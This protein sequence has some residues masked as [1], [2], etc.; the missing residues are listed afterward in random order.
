MS[1]GQLLF[2]PIL[3]LLNLFT[4]KLNA[5]VVA[6]FSAN[7]TSG[8]GSLQ[9]SFTD[10]STSSAGTISSWSW[11]L[12]GVASSSQNP[13]RIFG[14][15]GFYT[16]CLTATDNLGNSATECKQEYIQ[17]YQLPEPDFSVASQQGCV[18]F[19]VEFTDLTTLG[20]AAINQWIWGLGGSA[21][22]VV[23]DGSLNEIKT[24]YSAPDEY[25][26]SLTVI[27]DNNCSN[28][29]T[30]TDYISVTSPP[31]VDVS[32]NQ[33]FNCTPPFIVSFSN[34]GN[35]ANMDFNWDFGNGASF[36]GATPNPVV[37]NDPGY[38]TVTVIGTDQISG[39]S[40]T[41]VLLDYIQVGYPVEFSYDPLFTCANGSINFTDD[42]SN[43]ADSVL[44]D[45]G[46]GITSTAP[47]P[48]YTYP[49]QGCF[50]VSLTRYIGGCATTEVAQNCIIVHPNPT[51]SYSNNNSIGCD[52]PHQVDFS[53][54]SDIATQWFWDFGDGTTSTVQNPTHTYTQYGVFPV[55]LTVTDRNG[56]TNVINT[57][58]VEL[59]ALD[60]QLV[61]TRFFDCTPLSVT[62]EDQS[63]SIVPITTWEWHVINNASSPP[64]QVTSF[65]TVP[66]LTLIDTGRYD[67]ILIVTN[68]LGC[69]DTSL[70]QNMIGVG[71]PPTVDFSANPRVSCVS[72]SITFTDN[73]SSFSDEW[74]WDFG[75]G[76]LSAEQNP[77]YLYVDTG[78]FDVTLTAIH[79][80]CPNRLEID[81]FIHVTPPKARFSTDMNCDDPFTVSM[82]DN[83]I[84]ADTIFWDFGVPG[85]NADT[86]RERSPVFTY[87]ST[88]FY[89]VTQVVENFSTG[90]TDT[91]SFGFTIADP[92]ANFA[93][94]DVTGCVPVTVSLT[95]QSQDA[96]TYQWS[97]PGGTFSD[98]TT[99]SPRLTFD[100]P[101]AYS[102]IQL[103]ITDVNMC[104]DTM[105]F[106]DTIYANGVNLNFAIQPTT[107][108]QPLRV[109][110][111]ES[112]SSTF[113]TVIEWNWDFGDGQT[114]TIQ[115]PQHTFGTAGTYSPSLIVRDDWGCQASLQKTDSIDV[116]FPIA[117]FE[118]D[119]FGCTQYII[120]FI[121]QSQGKSLNYFWD[122]GDGRTS[123][124]N[125]PTHNYVNEG[126]YTVCLTVTDLY[127]CDST[128][129]RTDYIEIA[130]PVADFIADTIAASCPPLLVNFENRSQNANTYEWNF[131]DNSGSSNLEHPPHVYT[132]PGS[133]GVMLIATATE[134]CKD[135]LFL[136][137]L[138]QI[139][140]PLGDFS[141]DTDSA[142]IPSEVTFMGSSDGDYMYIWDY[143]NGVLDTSAIAA[144]TD[145]LGYT[146]TEIG[147]FIP[148]LI[149]VNQIGCARAIES[150]D[151][152]HMGNL[153]IDFLAQ[154]TVLCDQS[155]TSFF[156]TSNS[157]AP[158]NYQ[159]WIFENG[160]P[161]TSNDFE[162]TTQF[163]TAGNHDVHLIVDN[164]FCRD[165]LTKPDYI[166]V[167]ATPVAEF[168]ASS[169]E[170]CEP[171]SIQFTD[172]SNVAGDVITNWQWQFGDGNNSTAANPS[173]TFVNDATYP[174]Q[175]SVTSTIGCR[176]SITK[177]VIIRPKPEVSIDQSPVVCI[178]EISQLHATILTDP[179]STSA[180][181]VS[182]PTLSC[183]DCLDPFVTPMDTTVYTLI[184][185]NSFG[186]ADTTSTVVVV[187]PYPVPDITIS[188]DTTICANDVVQLFVNGGDDIYSYSWDPSRPGLTCYT[189]CFNPIASPSQLTTYTITVTN[190]WDCSS[191]DSVT[192]DVLN[193]YQP[194][195]GEDRTICEGDTVHLNASFGNNPNWLVTDGLDCTFCP[196]PM[197]KPD[198]TTTYL[199][200][201]TTDMGC[202]IIDTVTIN[203]MH[204]EDIDAGEDATVC[205][206]SST[207]L[208]GSLLSGTVSWSPS[209]GLSNTSILNPEA[210]PSQA[211]QYFMAVTNGECT[212]ID[213]VMVD[214][215]E[216]TVIEALDVTI[217]EGE[218]VRLETSGNA[219]SFWWTP[220]ENIAD[221]SVA[222]P[223]VSPTETTVY[224]VNGQL[225][226]CEAAEATVTVNVLPA[227]ELGVL[228]KRY[229][230]PGQVVQLN[231]EPDLSLPYEY[232]WFPSQGLTC[233]SCPNPAVTPEFSSIYHVEVTDLET[234]CIDTFTTEVILL[235][236]C[237]DDLINIPNIFTPNGDEQNDVLGLHLSPSL[238]EIKSFQIFNRWGA[239]I[240]A[241]T[242]INDFWDGTF[243]GQPLDSGVYVYLIEVPCEV[244]GNVI[245]KS[246]DITLLR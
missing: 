176:D 62:L 15:P 48:S 19:E 37:Y 76:G 147:S 94:S 82:I 104:Q 142:C 63:T 150:P 237:P 178:G 87:P 240:F 163:N 145:T 226:T 33:T 139:D 64:V 72:S 60:A 144:S 100:N 167:G 2:I 183:T 89:T 202:E 99:A 179:G 74:I 205:I 39:C 4:P 42:S 246:G 32:A 129:C 204:P 151:T 18:P 149:L 92:H 194:F 52:L 193:E 231:L 78:Y 53:G 113:G 109:D 195:A 140:G 12:G 132:I 41:L 229:F 14:T 153:E 236:H 234:G 7:V 190:Q 169:Y 56:C 3:L 67:I 46:D 180:E 96:D 44:W 212:L 219:D 211:T 171:V 141:F 55:T 165:T 28:T 59:L 49:I 57:D 108:C 199:V 117:A 158:I 23:D 206:G 143:G 88:G 97:S 191:R 21:G 187:K 105:L 103:I 115:N 198:S 214:V 43:P 13:G 85:T 243:K 38:Y 133:Y 215:M 71:M 161:D 184:S 136:D 98:P 101:G 77:N 112:S 35:T 174:V 9:V 128:L 124:E 122:F 138:I 123:T 203:V 221:P 230:F 209:T 16:I 222:N 65:D 40:D 146:Y 170:E 239:L 154:D 90:C 173:N 80:G 36:N 47:N 20:D 58:T 207:K 162:P 107:G 31:V 6:N 111:T 93:V 102:D 244:K 114:S 120:T 137:D 116:T 148:K 61:P 152:I 130:N 220:E 168:E 156:N 1:K 118:A 131:G 235:E 81:S 10:L 22:V 5:Q 95:D 25:T 8:C 75:D 155:S 121:N 126:I 70:F 208:N 227:P 189:D 225:S 51:V 233:S 86:S 69:V 224:T 11:D 213:S 177:D 106:T 73:S 30:K 17:V 188:N 134:N 217:C 26:I 66:N 216:T 242:D 238:K 110:F 210:S 29:I 186:C 192:V 196:A 197:S 157:S 232:N 83:S 34:N 54:N 200:S 45:F 27:D 160:T 245:I 172:Y 50:T 68:E 175:L 218:S 119:T 185:T 84:G 135:T 159:Q 241:T 24:T 181:W 127:G 164:G 125:N 223:T 166:K 182:D 79:L 201:V 91:T 228:P